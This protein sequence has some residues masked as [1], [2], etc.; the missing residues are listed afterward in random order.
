LPNII[1]EINGNEY[2]LNRES[3]FTLQYDV[4]VGLVMVRNKGGKVRI[5]SKQNFS[6]NE[7]KQIS[8]HFKTKKNGKYQMRYQFGT[9]NRTD[10]TRISSQYLP[11]KGFFD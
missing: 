9:I 3:Y 6:T 7:K 10:A 4:I 5:L 8:E 1:K 2:G 11:S